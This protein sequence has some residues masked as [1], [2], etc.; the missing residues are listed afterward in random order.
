MLSMGLGLAFANNA[1]AQ[2]GSVTLTPPAG[3]ATNY[4]SITSAY[5]AIPSAPAGNFLIEILAPYNGT[6]AS[7][8]YPIQLT[9]KGIA[10]ATPVITIRPAAG[11]NG[12]IIQRPVAAAGSV[13]Q[14]NGGDNVNLDGRPGGIVSTSANYLSINDL[15]SGSNANRNVEVLNAANNNIVQYINATAAEATAAGAGNRVLL[16]GG[17]T[18]T[19]NLNNTIQFCV[20]TGGLRGIQD[21]GLS[22]AAPNTGSRILNNTVRNFGSIGIFAGS[23]QANA[24][25]EFNTISMAGY[26][27]LVASATAAV[28]VTGIQQQSTLATNV[29]NISNNLVSLNTSSNT[30]TSLSG[31][32]DVGTGTGTV[33]RN[34]VSTLSAPLTNALA[35]VTN[36]LVAISIGTA[37]G[38]GV[39]THN[40]SNN[41]ISG[42]SSTGVVNVRGMSIFPFAGSTANVNNN[43][44]SITDPN[45]SAAAIFGLLFGNVAG[46]NYTSNIYYNSVRLGGTTSATTVNTYGIFKADANATSVYNQQNNIAVVDR[47]QAVAFNLGSTTGTLM[48]N[49]NNY[50]GTGA[51]NSSFAAGTATAN[52]DNTQLVAY[53]A[54]VTPQEQNTT[55]S[56]VIFVSNTDLHLAGTSITDLT[57]KGTSVPGIT[58]DFDNNTRSTTAPTKG[59]DEPG[60]PVPVSLF[61]FSGVSKGTFNQLTWSTASES[62]NSGFELQRSTDGQVFNALGFVSSKS[63]NGNSAATLSYSF[64]DRK[65]FTAGSYYRLK[66]IDKDGRFT[67]SN[68]IALKGKGIMGVEI[69][70]LYPNPV[71][72][73]FN[74]IMGAE[75]SGTVALIVTDVT[76]KIVLNKTVGVIMG[77]NIIPI[78]SASLNAGIYMLRVVHQQTNETATIQFIK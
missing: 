44:V 20:V 64:D 69:S 36:F 68:I 74:V 25:I 73:V 31:I 15:L 56:N 50:S 19:G 2:P 11:N 75:K 6:D 22:N 14:I 67:Y 61:V 47:S 70:N 39:A 21:F 12:E 16:I 27:V 35:G 1:I 59:A 29:S 30:V 18:T 49:F 72:D 4:P 66:Q 7:E 46:N 28:S 26:N 48:I 33:F 62:N 23:N 43:S 76:G 63:D 42:L 24:T 57:L 45:P 5:A 17:T 54:D 77:D 13:L 58:T 41:Y 8:V 9:D 40:V 52:Y 37:A 3:P 65:P 32:V 71:K 55:F 53:K 60:G 10:G 34:T 38:G 78:Q 51:A